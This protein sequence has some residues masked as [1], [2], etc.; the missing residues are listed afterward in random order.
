MSTMT[1]FTS[2]VFICVLI[3]FTKCSFLKSNTFI[4]LKQLVENKALS[5]MCF[6]NN[7]GTVFDLN[8]LYNENIDYQFTN[9]DQSYLKFNMCKNALTT[10][11]GKASGLVKY[12]TAN[13]TDCVNLAGNANEMSR[14][15]IVGK[16]YLIF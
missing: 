14:W 6:V 15:S 5:A 13:Q 1:K 4:E 10:C 8:P 3:A 7:N 11:E 2:L 9:L 12:I 16:I